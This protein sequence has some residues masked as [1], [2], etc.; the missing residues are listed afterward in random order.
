MSGSAWDPPGQLEEVSDPGGHSLVCGNRAA[1]GTALYTQPTISRWNCYYYYY[2]VPCV[3]L[4]MTL[5]FDCLHETW[6]YTRLQPPFSFAASSSLCPEDM[7]PRGGREWQK[8]PQ[9][10]KSWVMSS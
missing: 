9:V 1:V 8:E 4:Y 3:R 2:A 7:A 5:V 10:R 6:G